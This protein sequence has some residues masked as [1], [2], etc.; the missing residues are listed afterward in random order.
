MAS[1]YTVHGTVAHKAGAGLSEWLASTCAHVQKLWCL[2][3]QY[4]HWQNVAATGLMMI[5]ISQAVSGTTTIVADLAIPT[6]QE[7]FQS[8][9]GEA[10]PLWHCQCYHHC[11]WHF[12]CLGCPSFGA[13]RLLNPD[14]I[15]CNA[16]HTTANRG[17][18]AG[19]LQEQHDAVGHVRPT[20]I[21]V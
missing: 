1:F 11:K 21:V 2:F 10:Q 15:P 4:S 18:G 5:C 19:G 9:T 14:S 8:E 7:T 17:G 13:R 16:Q 12:Q 3:M 20:E 6:C